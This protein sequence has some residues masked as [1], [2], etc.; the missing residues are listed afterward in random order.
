M[1]YYF[2]AVANSVGRG[3]AL[4]FWDADDMP[5]LV[6][7]NIEILPPRVVQPLSCLRRA[8]RCLALLMYSGC[9]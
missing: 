9:G 3:V 6:A 1:K 5:P 8:R 4:Q 7:E 2:A